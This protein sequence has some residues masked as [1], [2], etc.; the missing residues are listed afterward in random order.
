MKREET[1]TVDFKV[2]DYSSIRL[3]QLDT[4]KLIFRILDNSLAVDLAN[5]TARIIFKKP[6][7]NNSYSGMYDCE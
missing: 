1:I 6:R 4:T 7:R 2:K 3:K 5:K